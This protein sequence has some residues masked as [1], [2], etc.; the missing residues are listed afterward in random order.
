VNR[1]EDSIIL[2]GPIRREGT[3]TS[4]QP[5]G[6]LTRSR[7]GLDG[8]LDLLT[9]RD[10]RVFTQLDHLAVDD[11]LNADFRGGKPTDISRV[12][13]AAGGSSVVELDAVAA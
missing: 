6:P 2:L 9:V 13:G 7:Q 10:P 5:L 8:D 1:F 12:S 3:G 11:A 4:P